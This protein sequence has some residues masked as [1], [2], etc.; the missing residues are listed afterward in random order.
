MV[1]ELPVWIDV[2]AVWWYRAIF[3]QLIRMN[4]WIQVPNILCG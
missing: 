4:K 3:D 2:D 1:S